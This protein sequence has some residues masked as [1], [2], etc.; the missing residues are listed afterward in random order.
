MS[1]LSLSVI[2]LSTPFRVATGTGVSP[3]HQTW[4]D[5]KAWSTDGRGKAAI[6][7]EVHRDETLLIQQYE[8]ALSEA[9]H[10]TDKVR[11]VLQKQLKTIRE[12]DASVC[13]F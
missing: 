12:Q 1:S 10:L 6:V 2:Y 5:V 3:A 11:H 13:V 4:T 7:A 8:A 9:E